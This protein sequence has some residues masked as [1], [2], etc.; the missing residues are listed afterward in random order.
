MQPWA[1]GVTSCKPP[2]GCH[3]LQFPPRRSPVVSMRCSEVLHDWEVPWSALPTV[4][5]FW[6]D[7]GWRINLVQVA[8]HPFRSTC[9]RHFSAPDI[10][11]LY[12]H[13]PPL[14]RSLPQLPSSKHCNPGVVLWLFAFSDP[15]DLAHF[16]SSPGALALPTQPSQSPLNGLKSKLGVMRDKEPTGVLVQELPCRKRYI[17]YSYWARN[18]ICCSIASFSSYAR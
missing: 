1:Q 13:R 14:S 9:G 6:L 11:S 17:I 3:S 7:L 4:T 18:K 2:L 15:G 10:V 16:E 12:H 8:P 5:A